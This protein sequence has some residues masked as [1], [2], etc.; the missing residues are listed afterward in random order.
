MP[1]AA[2]RIE[3]PRGED[4]WSENQADALLRMVEDIFHRRDLEALVNGFT[5][6]C[7]VR[8]S[9]VPEFRGREKLRE[10][11]AARFARQQNYRLAK[12]LRMLRGNQLGNVWTGTWTDARNGR[13]ME[14]FGVEFWTMRDGR[15][16]VWE[17]SF[18]VWEAG[19]ER[20]SGVT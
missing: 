20:S 14:G 1:A 16:A 15:I 13:P 8:F 10:L 18:S 4:A 3:F 5:E 2:N 12:T 7:V 17:A 19:G 11:F 6:D 9:A